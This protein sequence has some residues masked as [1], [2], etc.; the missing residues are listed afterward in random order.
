MCS[1]AKQNWNFTLGIM[2]REKEDPQRKLEVKWLEIQEFQ[3]YH[4]CL[5]RVDF[6]KGLRSPSPSITALQVRWKD[7]G[8]D[9]QLHYVADP[10]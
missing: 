4:N 6:H 3:L 2:V 9:C 7:L 1:T 5:G 8:I 10:Y